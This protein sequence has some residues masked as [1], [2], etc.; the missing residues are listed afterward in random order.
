MLEPVS[1]GGPEAPN[2]GHMGVE[3]ESQQGADTVA[4]QGESMAVDPVVEAKRKASTSALTVSVSD[5]IPGGRSRSYSE[6]LF[7]SSCPLGVLVDAPDHVQ[8]HVPDDTLDQKGVRKRNLSI[9]ANEILAIQMAV[10]D[11]KRRR[12]ECHDDGS[13]YGLSLGILKQQH[14]EPYQKELKKLEELKRQAHL[15]RQLYVVVDVDAAAIDKEMKECDVKCAEVQRKIEDIGGLIAAEALYT[16]DEQQLEHVKE[17]LVVFHGRQWN[18][19][20]DNKSE[21]YRNLRA[22]RFRKIAKLEILK[23]QNRV[24]RSFVYHVEIVKNKNNISATF[25]IMLVHKSWLA[26]ISADPKQIKN[27]VKQDYETWLSQ[28]GTK[29]HLVLTRV[30]GMSMTPPDCLSATG[31][32]LLLFLPAALRILHSF[33]TRL[34]PIP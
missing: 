31:P 26:D 9:P 22:V 4:V 15:R 19:K 2:S 11:L 24:W 32:S 10:G 20:R 28:Y 6:A 27:K 29:Y 33:T 18:F 1:E 5:A 14:I 3:R 34:A 16:D 25:N 17:D 13:D 8:D 30:G 12:I 23:C 7:G 21:Q